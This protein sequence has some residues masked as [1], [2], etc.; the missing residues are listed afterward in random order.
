MFWCVT[1]GHPSRRGVFIALLARTNIDY[2]ALD[3]GEL[4]VQRAVAE[5][6]KKIED[7][8]KLYDIQFDERYVFGDWLDFWAFSP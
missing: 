7:V 1:G 6:K 2:I 8:N 4:Q 5:L 3:K